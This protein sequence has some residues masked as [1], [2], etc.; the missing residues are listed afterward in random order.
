MSTRDNVIHKLSSWVMDRLTGKRASR[1]EVNEFLATLS[2][3]ARM[4]IWKLR[5]FYG[6]YNRGR[7]N[8]R[9]VGRRGPYGPRKQDIVDNNTQEVPSLWHLG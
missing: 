4:G 6:R 9:S 1:D 7:V 8:R 2:P 3:E 5:T